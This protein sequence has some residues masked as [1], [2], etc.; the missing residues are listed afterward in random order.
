MQSDCHPMQ[1]CYWVE[2]VR[3]EHLA[4]S[5]PYPGSMRSGSGRLTAILYLIEANAMW[6]NVVDEACSQTVIQSRSATGS[7]QS[8][9]SIGQIVFPAQVVCDLEVIG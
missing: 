6:A 2:A 4:H 1:V 8:G 7:R 5:F 3:R 9:E